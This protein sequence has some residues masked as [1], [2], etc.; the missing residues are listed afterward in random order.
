MMLVLDTS[1]VSVVMRRE[2]HALERLRALKPG[3]V[4]LCSPVAGEIRFGLE[5]LPAG[6][7]RRELLEAEYARLRS[8]VRWS[9]W[10]ESAA[11]HFGVH[12]A[13]LERAR[14]RVGDMDVIIASVALALGAGVATCNP[15]HFQRIEGLRVEDWRDP[16]S[17]R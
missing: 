5:R 3:D 11:G 13:E 7:R 10:T 2:P 12:K 4:V 9:D 17:L 1:A 16:A 6:S 15:R 14:A 8:A